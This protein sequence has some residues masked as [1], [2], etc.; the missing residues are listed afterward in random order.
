MKGDEGDVFLRKDLN[1]RLQDE[2]L[3]PPFLT[4]LCVPRVAPSLASSF[5][6]LHSAFNFAL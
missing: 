1:R 3:K 6:I 2:D 4:R 5:I